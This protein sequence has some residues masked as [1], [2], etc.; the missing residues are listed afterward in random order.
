[1]SFDAFKSELITSAQKFFPEACITIIEKRSI[2]VETRVDISEDVFLEIY[3]NALT[4]KKR[5]I[6]MTTQAQP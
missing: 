3:Y 4:G 2:I 1:M 5:W 6:V